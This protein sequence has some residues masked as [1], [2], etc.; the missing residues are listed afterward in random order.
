MAVYYVSVNKPSD[1][2]RETTVSMFMYIVY[3][4]ISVINVKHSV[5]STGMP[6]Q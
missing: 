5:Q 1:K 3:M 6:S 2:I 4:Q